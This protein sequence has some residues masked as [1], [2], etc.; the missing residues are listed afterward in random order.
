MAH[1][2]AAI[3]IVNIARIVYTTSDGDDIEITKKRLIRLLQHAIYVAHSINN[4]IDIVTIIDDQIE[5]MKNLICD[6]QNFQLLADT[7]GEYLIDLAYS[8]N[9]GDYEIDI[10]AFE[11]EL[12]MLQNS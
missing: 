3:Q 5:K 8:V 6:N 11:D 2:N 1:V 9:I 7:Q 4:G 12:A 10:A